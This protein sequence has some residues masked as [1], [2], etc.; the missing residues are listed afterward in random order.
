VGP[1]SKPPRAEEWD[2]PVNL[3]ADAYYKIVSVDE[4]EKIEGPFVDWAN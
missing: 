1:Y 2:A 3:G 4:L